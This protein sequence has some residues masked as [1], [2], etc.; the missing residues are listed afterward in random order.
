MPQGHRLCLS[1]LV[2]LRVELQADWVL[3]ARCVHMCLMAALHLTALTQHQVAAALHPP[4]NQ[5]QPRNLPVSYR[6]TA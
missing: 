6:S 2:S 5:V 4:A 1:P 3:H